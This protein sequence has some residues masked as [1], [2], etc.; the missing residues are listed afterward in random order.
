MAEIFLSPLLQICFDKLGSPALRWA[1]AALGFNLA[2]EIKN[3]ESTLRMIEVVLEEAEARQGRDKLVKLWLEK[4]KDA[5]Y[6]AE[7][8]LE[9]L[10][11]ERYNRLLP[12]KLTKG[13]ELHQIQNRL[14]AIVA[15]KSKFH[16][17]EAALTAPINTVRRK[18]TGSFTVESKVY[19][20]AEDKEKIIQLL[21][22][23]NPC[24]ISVVPIVGIGGL[25]K[26]TLARLAYNENRIDEN[27]DLK[28]WVCVTD[29]F[30][31]VRLIKSIIESATKSK[32][33][34]MVMDALQ[35]RL[36]AL[37]SGKRYLLV[38]DDVWN[39]DQDV[40]D[41]FKSLLTGGAN[42]SKIIVT[43]R[44]KK[45]ATIMGS[46]STYDLQGLSEDDCWALFKQRAFGQVEEK[47][48][49]QNLL[50][51]GKQIIKKCSG[52]PLAANTIGS[53]MRFK[54]EETEWLFV[55]ESE[56]WNVCEGENGILPAL[57]LSYNHLPTHLKPCF[58]YCSIFPKNFEIKKEKL[59]HQW[60]A[61]GYIK[62]FEH[63]RNVEDT[64]EEYFNDL[65][66][67]SFLQGLQ[68]GNDGR[69][70]KCK[71]HDV[72]HDLATSVSESEFMILEHGHEPGIFAKTR[73]S[74][75]IC[76]FKQQKFPKDL[77][78]AKNLRTL[79]LSSTMGE[80][81]IGIEQLRHLNLKGELQIQHL[82]NVKDKNQKSQS[83][84]NQKQNGDILEAL[85]P[86]KYLKKLSIHGYRG[87]IFPSWIGNHHVQYLTEVTLINCDFWILPR[88]GGLRFLKVLYM[89]RMHSL[90]KIH[91]SF[92]HLSSHKSF[93]LLQE[94]TLKEI[95]N[96]EDWS[97]V[98]GEDVLPSLLKLVIHECPILKSI[99]WCP[100]LQY[101]ELQNCNA[102]ILNSAT[103]LTALC[104]IVINSLPELSF[105]PGGFL[106]NSPILSSLRI[107]SCPNLQSLP[108]E[109]GKLGSLKSLTIRWCQQLASLPELQN[110]RSLE[111]L[112]ISEC[113]SIVSF[114][115]EAMQGL[116]SLRSLSIEN[117]NNLASLP[118]GMQNLI[119]LED[120]TVMYCPKL[121]S[122]PEDLQ[123]LTALRS[124]IVLSC[125]QLETLPEGLQHVT[126]LQ[127]LEI[128]SCSGL[129]ALPIWIE[130]LN[131]LRSLAISDCHKLLSL[132]E[133]LQRLTALQHLSIQECPC[134]E[135]RCKRDGGADW[136][137]ISHI[138]HIHIGRIRS[139]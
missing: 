108:A 83:K 13:N 137:K 120:L 84:M 33:E 107:S 98:A 63:R 19:G 55:Q 53:L 50:A 40:W 3:L 102:M 73:H 139:A 68:E 24:N 5:A 22:D 133:G 129:L 37:L 127:I 119:A 28:I 7:D 79:L 110:L 2:I 118:V 26:T 89:H 29:D 77:L 15:E 36:W 87:I 69:I 61:Q 95:P 41:D 90:G 30:D 92:N 104:T 132:P 42:G 126:T 18:Q 78:E 43:T 67:M 35:S 51:I 114:P 94:L 99:P 131:S 38:L 20:R 8:F 6:D 48:E 10:M 58:V 91:D 59:I 66:A 57:R 128:R 34:N 75:V 80:D 17:N 23:T 85:K 1:K 56:L 136:P 9:G 115:E 71:T 44:N 112:E 100:S 81:G 74:T 103:D 116:S 125:P 86:G 88:L 31:V 130:N 14:D 12:T 93:P 32:C 11:A 64:G 105:L 60:I 113:H 101:L 109:L 39:E 76:D 97:S 16:F 135:R 106:E 117:C 46:T 138:P 62:S 54:R 82:E 27:F 123:H 121:V 47:E 96:L 122:L 134:L 70:I 45:V 72:I 124:L 52:V 21:L 4:L 111:S 25:G 49:H 65:L